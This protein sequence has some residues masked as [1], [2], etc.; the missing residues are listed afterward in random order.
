MRLLSFTAL[1][2]DK[3]I[4]YS[5]VWIRELI[6]RGEFPR[7]IRIGL[8]RVGFVESEVDEWLRNRVAERDAEQSA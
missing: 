8:N 1:K 3:G 4:P 7:P 5:S 2:A 6:A